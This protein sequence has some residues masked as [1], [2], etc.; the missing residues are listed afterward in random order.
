MLCLASVSFAFASVLTCSLSAVRLS[1]LRLSLRLRELGLRRRLLRFS[2]FSWL[3]FAVDSVFT[4][5][6]AGRSPRGLEREL[7]RRRWLLLRRRL[8]L[9]PRRL[10]LRVCCCFSCSA[11]SFACF[12]AS[13]SPANNDLNQLPIAANRPPSTLG[14]AT[15][16]AGL[17][18]LACGAGVEGITTPLSIGSSRTGAAAGLAISNDSG[19]GATTCS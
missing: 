14:T 8:S 19:S 16:A 17:S 10:L 15:G 6:S 11:F 5:S 4:S 1:L 13:L 3:S 9:L 12:S 2:F 7:L 18:T